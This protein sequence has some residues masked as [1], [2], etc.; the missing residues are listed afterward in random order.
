MIEVFKEFT[1]EAAHSIPPY[2]NVHGH[3]FLVEVVVRGDPDERFGW[4]ISLNDIEPHIHEVQKALDHKYL[5]EIEGLD[6]PSLEN[7]AIWIWTRL[8]ADVAGIHR[9]MVRRGHSGQSEGCTLTAPL[10][11]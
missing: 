5:N 1:F 3:S 7:L 10:A 11:A 4:P 6:V 9:I 8:D 2:S